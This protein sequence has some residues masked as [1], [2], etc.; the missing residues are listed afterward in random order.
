MAQKVMAEKDIFA[1]CG[2][3]TKERVV[4][5]P[6]LRAEVGR[7]QRSCGKCLDY[8]LARPADQETAQDHQ[9]SPP[10]DQRGRE[11]L[12]LNV[13]AVG[14]VSSLSSR[15]SSH[16]RDR[17]SGKSGLFSSKST[18]LIETAPGQFTNGPH[19]CPQW[20]KWK[21]NPGRTVVNPFWSERGLPLILKI[22]ICKFHSHHCQ[23]SLLD[24]YMKSLS[25]EGQDWAD[26]SLAQASVF[27][28]SALPSKEVKLVIR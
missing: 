28:T 10:Q 1:P 12:F 21:E 7:A 2:K 27:L 11:K 9:G 8:H 22:E 23:S 16:Q 13:G 20:A 4:G 15:E 3:Q 14:W 24:Q 5:G 17:C 18:L 6:A 26:D 19:V 25:E